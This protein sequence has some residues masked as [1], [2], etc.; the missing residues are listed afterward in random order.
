MGV[1][2]HT[3]IKH[4]D[5]KIEIFFLK[6]CITYVENG[7]QRDHLKQ[8]IVVVPREEEMELDGR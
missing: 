8:V 1:F 4:K 2:I 5:V 3:D 6:A 7:E